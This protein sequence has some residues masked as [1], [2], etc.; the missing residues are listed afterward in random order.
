MLHDF[1]VPSVLI[2]L[3]LFDHLS[4][5]LLLSDLSPWAVENIQFSASI[6]NI[7]VFAQEGAIFCFD[8]DGTRWMV[9][10]ALV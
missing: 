1:N 5:F 4:S 10:A 8:F 2:V 6:K 9:S 3:D 7:C